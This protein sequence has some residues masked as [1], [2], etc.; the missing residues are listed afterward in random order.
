MIGRVLAVVA[1]G[2]AALAA[3]AGPAAALEQR[4]IAVSPDHPAHASYGPIP[5]SDLVAGQAFNN[6]AGTCR[7]AGPCDLVP[8]VLSPVRQVAS[9]DL[10]VK[11][12]VAWDGQGGDN[13]LMVQV[14]DPSHEAAGDYP[15]LQAPKGS[16][17]VIEFL[18][19][20]PTL[21]RYDLAVTNVVGAN[22]GYRIDASLLEVSRTA[23]TATPTTDGLAPPHG[24]PAAGTRPTTSSAATATALELPLDR[25][26]SS[27]R[28]LT[29]H[30]PSIEK[31]ASRAV[32][33]ML[34]VFALVLP[35][36]ALSRS[37]RVLAPGRRRRLSPRRW[38]R[39]LRLFWKLLV[40]FVAAILV[41]GVAGTFLTVHYLASRAATTLDEHLLDG[42]VG[43]STYL[44][45]HELS[46]LEAV[47]FAANVEGVPEGV[48]SS[49]RTEA[50][51]ALASAVAVHKNLDAI[52]VT[53]V[54]GRG[55]VDYTRDTTALSPHEGVD[56]RAAPCVEDVL[57]GV[58]DAAG[59]KHTCFVR[60]SDRT[61]LLLLAGPIRTDHVVGAAVAGVTADKLARGAAE[62]AS[63][64]VAL[65]DTAG[66]VMAASPRFD[67][68]ARL[69]RGIGTRPV[70]VREDAGG[71]DVATLYE[72]FTVR[73][74]RVGTIA[75]R[76][77]VHSAFAS[78][79]GAAYRLGALVAL[80]MLATIALGVLLSRY[81]VSGLGG[82]LATTRALGDGDLGAR[83][84]VT[85]GD[86]VGE[87]AA[88]VNHM[89][90]ALQES[91]ENLEAKVE[92]RTAEVQRLL[93]ERTAF[94]TAVSHDL[95]T[96]LAVILGQ[97]E[98][99]SEP[100]ARVVKDAGHQLLGFV[101]DILEMAKVDAGRIELRRERVALA[102][103]I[104]DMRPSLE[105]LAT[106]HG[107]TFTVDVPRRLPDV[108]IDVS[109]LRQIVVNLVDN[110]VKYTPRGGHVS[111]TAAPRDGVV[112]V[113]VN[114]T[115]IG[116]PPDAGDRLF[117]PFYRA[118]GAQAQGGQPSSG[119]GLAVVRGLVEAHGGRIWFESASGGTTFHFTI[120]TASPPP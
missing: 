107:V 102:D 9:G 86:E 46:L 82:V 34:A 112:E 44:R 96:P 27:L 75:V 105:S 36:A 41:I 31:R 63:A 88:G 7:A 62:R 42:G 6:D 110:A 93:R 38:F 29:G 54:M 21:S 52:S 20:D 64:G 24:T 98:M 87:L 117:E 119:L 92:E 78:V 43:A 10:V 59:D 25:R 65:Y 61:I 40:P 120:P 85:T 95:R 28:A 17:G 57:H 76:V 56:W 12:R 2:F 90:S 83:T 118:R 67:A 51:R 114:D 50:A 13:R 80:V 16:I 113:C 48:A 74:T 4:A 89:A 60:L 106:T 101:N 115:G 23:T 32:M 70:R 103:A 84:A 104:A 72:P 49:N 53:D 8:L 66:R 45:D 116:I 71:R 97:A 14:M 73:G 19:P 68:R 35:T 3:L 99:I 69:D 5:G 37:R 11:V 1:I 26:L 81:F 58:T 108:D 109:R 55:F 79:R 39:D 18:L 100:A 30:A 15:V 111:V 91:Y 77:S 33:I 47:R 94:F 22:T